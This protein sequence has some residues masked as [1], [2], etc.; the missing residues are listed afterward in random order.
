VLVRSSLGVERPNRCER[1]LE[2][3]DGVHPLVG[4][5]GVRTHPGE[6][7]R[8][9]EPA[10][11]ARA[12]R[13]VRWFAHDVGVR[14]EVQCV[15]TV[16][17]R[18]LVGRNREGHPALGRVDGEERG[19]QRCKRSLRVAGAAPTDH[20]TLPR[21]PDVRRHRV[22]VGVEDDVGVAALARREHVPAVV[23]VRV[24]TVIA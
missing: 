21:E 24:L 13:E 22:D 14:V 1:T 10:A 19:E 9:L 5:R 6:F 3:G 12:R 18:L 17:V 8:P 20:V 2:G 15:R 11:G 4:A 7:D 23:H 16:R